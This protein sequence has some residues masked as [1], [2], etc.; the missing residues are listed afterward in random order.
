MRLRRDYFTSPIGPLRLLVDEQDRLR[1]LDFEGGREAADAALRRAH[2]PLTIVDGAAPDSVRA[3]LA[4]YFTGDLAALERIAVATSGGVFQEAAWAALRAIPVGQTR[5]YAQQ[6]AAIGRPAA[7]RAIGQA[8]HR[9]PVAI[10]NPCHRVIGANG[11]LTGYGGGLDRK[12]WLL[13]HEG[14]LVNWATAA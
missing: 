2:G 1:G 14:V 11:Q 3:P 12:I 6:A 5:T 9:N 13:R 4:A 8:N 10:V 7:M